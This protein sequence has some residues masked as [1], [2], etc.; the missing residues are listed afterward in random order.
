MVVDWFR[1]LQTTSGLQSYAFIFPCPN[2][3]DLHSQLVQ[4]PGHPPLNSGTLGNHHHGLAAQ[5]WH[6][7]RSPSRSCST[8]LYRLW[9]E[10][11]TGELLE[12]GPRHSHIRLQSTFCIS[13]WKTFLGHA[14]HMPETPLTLL[15]GN[16]AHPTS[17]GQV[18]LWNRRLHQDCGRHRQYGNRRMKCMGAVP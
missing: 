12:A 8:K 15:P 14:S 9:R 4:R 16:R 13:V 17:K 2:H 5:C 18:H 6:Q 3:E 1:R 11:S 10:T 7:V